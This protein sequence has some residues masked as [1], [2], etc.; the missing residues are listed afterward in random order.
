MPVPRTCSGRHQLAG[1]ANIREIQRLL[2]HK[3]LT[4]TALYTKVDV[5]ALAA[6]IWLC[7][8]RERR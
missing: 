2:G 7:H 1:G 3:D 5:R 6:M 8:P 4:T